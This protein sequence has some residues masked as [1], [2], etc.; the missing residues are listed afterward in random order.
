MLITKTSIDTLQ[1]K[2]LIDPQIITLSNNILWLPDISDIIVTKTS[3][4]TLQNK[5]LSN[6]LITGMAYFS[7]DITI[8]NKATI[9]TI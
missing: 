6:P 1:N 9:N 8:N 4:D 7:D 3:T 2:T 5:T